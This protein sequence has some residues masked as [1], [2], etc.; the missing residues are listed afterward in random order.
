MRSVEKVPMCSH[1]LSF[2]FLQSPWRQLGEAPLVR[3][4]LRPWRHAK[5]GEIIGKRTY[6][7]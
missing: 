6:E 5:V 3:R 2:A 4:V 1:W 7:K